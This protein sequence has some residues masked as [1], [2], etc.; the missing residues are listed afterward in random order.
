M[1]RNKPKPVPRRGGYAPKKQPHNPVSIARKRQD[2]PIGKPL[3]PGINDALNAMASLNEYME[4]FATTDY[5]VSID[6][7]EDRW[8]LTVRGYDPQIN[9]YAGYE[10][11]YLPS[12]LIRN[13]KATISTKRRK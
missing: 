6:M 1:N 13:P 8:M 2:K 3:V 11:R 7:L 4:G 5:T 12:V 10:V 9:H